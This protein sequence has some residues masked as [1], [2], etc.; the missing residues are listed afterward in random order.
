M[1]AAKRKPA[2]K[3]AATAR[4][5]TPRV[6]SFD[7]AIL[8]GGPAGAAAARCLAA[9]GRRVVVLTRPAPGP[10]LAESL[11]PSV[12][13]VLARTGLLDAV[14]RSDAIRSS[15]HLVRWGG[16]DSREEPFATGER[17]W[18]VV[19]DAFDRTLLGAVADAGAV[20]HRHASVRGVRVSRS[21]HSVTYEERG[22]AREVSAAW[23]VDCTGRTGLMSR[24]GSTRSAAGPRTTAIVGVWERRAGWEVADWRNTIVESYD[25]GWAWSVPL[26]RT[27]RQVTVMLDPKRTALAR[28]TRLRLTYREELARTALLRALIKGARFHGSP[29]AR[30]A[31]AYDCARPALG[32]LLL[33]GDAAS[34]VDP[35]SSF[36]VKK[37]L[38][39]GWLAAVAIHSAMDDPSVEGPA[40]ELFVAR[41]HAMVAGLRKA[42]AALAGEAATAHADGYWSDRA[43]ADV[44]DAG[45]DPDLA[46]IRGDAAIRSAFE[47]LRGASRIRLL[48]TPGVK[49]VA[50]AVVEGDRVVVRDHL[51]LRGFPEGVRFIRNIDLVRLTEL[52]SVSEDPAQVAA[53]YAKKVGPAT[54][55][56]VVSALAVLLGSG[57]LTVA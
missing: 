48:P 3:K 11:T 56:D 37:A 22:R 15:G 40:L 36:G 52:A 2:K 34:F 55:P 24:A 7:V 9:W 25:G 4:V 21:E 12:V 30:D 23:V 57:A 10:P 54:I 32:R 39:S 43:V 16:A 42:A 26:T 46:M 45:G 35:L 44:D 18:Q 17:G 5:A 8:G 28:G 51:V 27:R 20:V 53:A 38:A 1:S 31:S 19:R 33:A 41:E 49:R 29:W 13:K 47:R 50:R 6:E 14:E